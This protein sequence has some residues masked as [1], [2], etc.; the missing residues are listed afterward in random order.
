M[1]FCLFVVLLLYVKFRC[2]FGLVSIIFIKCIKVPS[3]SSEKGYNVVLNLSIR[4]D[5][6]KRLRLFNYIIHRIIYKLYSLP[7]SR[8]VIINLGSSC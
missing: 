6:T 8:L 2:E 1:L 7:Q 4:H 5:A 3:L